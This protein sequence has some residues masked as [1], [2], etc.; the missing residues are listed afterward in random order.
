MS[1]SVSKADK[2]AAVRA[3]IVEALAADLIGP[4]EPQQAEEVLPRSPSRWYLTGFLAPASRRV[5]TV[6]DEDK[7]TPDDTAA[8][9]PP[10]GPDGSKGDPEEPKPKRRMLFPA[11]LGLSVLLRAETK[12]ITADVTW[13]DY[14]PVPND[15]SD[16]TNETERERRS[17]SRS[18]RPVWR[19]VPRMSGP[20][21]ITLDEATA[22]QQIGDTGLHLEHRVAAAAG[23]GLD[24]GAMA[25]SLF[26]V[27]RRPPVEGPEADSA[28]AFQVSLTLTADPKLGLCPRP[29]HRGE[30][31]D[32]D[33][34]RIA[35]LQ[36]RGQREWAVGHGVAA[37]PIRDAKS[38][39]IGARTVFIPSATV[40]LVQT[41]EDLGSEVTLGMEVLAQAQDGTALRAGLMGLADRYR[42]WI[43]KERHKAEKL[44]GNRQATA[45]KLVA[46][47]SIA[48]ER[49][50][51][52]VELLATDSQVRSAFCLANDA[53]ARQA[54]RRKKYA[55]DKGPAWRPFQLAFLLL[56]LP[57]VANDRHPDRELVDL[58][59]F[60][61]GGGKTEAY[62]GLAAFILILRRMR[63]AG[64]PDQGLGVA[65][66]LRYTLRL[67]TLDQLGRAATLICALERLRLEDPK[68]LGSVRFSLGLWVGKNATPNNMVGMAAMVEAF[69]ERP[70]DEVPC[71]LTACPWCATPLT[72]AS[73]EIR[74][75]GVRFPE[76]RLGCVSTTGQCPFTLSA[77]SEGLPIIYVD[78]QLY[79]ELPG[80]VIATVDKL[81][82]LPYKGQTA[83]LFG[84]VAARD[85]RTFISFMDRESDAARGERLPEG[86]RPPDLIIQD[87]LHLISGPLG[88][89]VGLYEMAVDGLCSQAVPGAPPVRPKV[90]ASTATVRRARQ[91]ITALFGRT[92]APAM[93]PPIGID[94]SDSF[95]GEQEPPGSHGRLYVGIAAPGRPSKAVLLRVYVALLTAAQR[96]F[97]EGPDG[98]ELADAYMT[99]V[100]YF[101]SL[102]ELGGMRRLVE[103]EVR[104][105][106]DRRPAPSAWFTRRPLSLEPLELTSREDTHKITE[107]KR[108]L[109]LPHGQPDAV[110]VAL[111]TNMISVG[112][113]VPRLGLMVVA[114]Q[115]KSTSEY[116]QATSR[117]GRDRERPGLVV[118]VFNA[119][120]PRDRSH[121]EHFQSFHE[122]FYANVEATSVTP[123]SGPALDRGLAGALV[124]LMRLGDPM[125]IPSTAAANL[126]TYT[127]RRDEVLALIAER[128]RACAAI[129]EGP[130]AADAHAA[131][132]RQRAAVLFDSWASLTSAAKDGAQGKV[133]SQYDPGCHKRSALLMTRLEEGQREHDTDAARFVAPT[134]MRDVEAPVPLWL[135]RR[136]LGKAEGGHGTTEK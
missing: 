132:V 43:A 4:T 118:V 45:R 81:A 53:M 7:S 49:M 123:F 104:I 14:L 11:S 26:V 71:P 65:V 133:Y 117:V 96:A 48:H 36:Y 31:S 101:N 39:V 93:F 83:A 42:D 135:L 68:R 129:D 74:E 80:F 113:D 30:S 114:G 89:M 63:A 46:K 98:K 120:R 75:E 52:G 122:A 136:G 33:D 90:V 84:R 64:R 102:R 77:N 106:C 127:D 79:R 54:R 130:A 82:M 100:G 38:D 56:S 12:A 27:N 99:L 88:T 37:E 34:D 76:V 116:I 108:R 58:I 103:D 18:R 73:V 16:A 128:A 134:S 126:A 109:E 95:F 57:S 1:A 21:T 51:E 72:K 8:E 125:L 121:Y 20:L 110:D 112:V 55:D 107:A 70:D 25:L 40:P 85:G 23:P 97:Q 94:A 15:A 115:P 67:L 62:L 9:E 44:T 61:T 86:L 69:R 19:R 119:F 66:L 5:V 2:A 3:H 29:R 111:A 131:K 92:R 17:K 87:E 60:P 78:D 59:F 47:A 10:A 50:I 28:F 41:K 32:D 35:D 6:A 24:K 105:R 91:Q 22:S 13:A 124:A